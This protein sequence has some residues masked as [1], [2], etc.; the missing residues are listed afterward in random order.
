MT[1]KHTDP[2]KTRGGEDF[3]P[4]ARVSLPAAP[5]MA[6]S[7][8]AGNRGVTPSDPGQ[9]LPPFDEA[10]EAGAL[11]CVVSA[12]PQQA[13]EMV[14]NLCLEHFYDERHRAIYRGLRCLAADSKPLDTVSLVQWLRAKGQTDDAGGLDYVAA[15]GDRTPS[16][17]NFPT[18]YE[19]LNDHQT[20]RSCIADCSSLIEV[21]RDTRKP[22]KLIGYAASKLLCSYAAKAELPPVID[23][24]EFVAHELPQPPELVGGI[25]HQG[26]KLVLGG[27][28][29]SFKTWTLLDLA[30]SVAHGCQWLGRNTAQGRVLYLNF[31]IQPW[32]WQGRVGAVAKGKG[33]TLKPGQLS[34]WNLR[35]RAN[36]YTVLLPQIQQAAK[37][38]YSLIVLDPIY[39]LYGQTDENSAGDVAKLLNAIDELCTRTGAATAFGA[40]FSKGI[41]SGKDSIDRISGSGVFA[42][43]PDSLLIFTAH[44]EA[45]AF[46]V[47]A[48]LRNFPRPEPFVVR[49]EYPLMVPDLQLDP[50]KLK[51]KAGR[52][53]AHQPEELCAALAG[54][55]PATVSGW[56]TA[57]GIPRQTLQ[58]YV[59]GLRA[60]GLIMTLGEGSTAKQTLTEAGMAA[61]K[62]HRNGKL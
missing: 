51:T 16:P 3:T 6:S 27:G 36:D 9:E 10:A 44:E 50:T 49:W 31:E 7:L 20:R 58:S 41:Q 47:E 28:S 14:T 32:S 2:D 46:T 54:I 30:V 23:A 22:A 13:Q 17:A 61:A 57:A 40:H 34:L 60:S 59:P 43:D 25:L 52:K 18:F 8:P 11:G 12:E 24:A 39:K 62:A 56:A 37:R 35:G 4:T 1:I 5:K 55:A 15:I 53:R 19:S 38:D 26:S 21:A 29:K 42:R 48:T 45:D 33:I